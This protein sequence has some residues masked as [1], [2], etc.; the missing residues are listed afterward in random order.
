MSGS[1]L[2]ARICCFICHFWHSMKSFWTVV[3]TEETVWRRLSEKLLTC[4]RL[5]NYLWKEPADESITT[6][7][8]LQ[9]SKCLFFVPFRSQWCV[10]AWR[11]PSISSATRRSL[12]SRGWWRDTARSISWLLS[13]A[14][15]PAPSAPH[16]LWWTPPSH[17]WKDAGGASWRRATST[18]PWCHEW[19]RPAA[20]YTTSVRTEETA[21]CRSGTLR[22][23]PLQVI[24][25]SPTLN[26]M[27]RTRTALLRWSDTPSPITCWLYCSTEP[28]AG[29]QC[30]LSRW[31]SSSVETEPSLLRRRNWVVCRLACPLLEQLTALYMKIFSKFKKA[32][33]DWRLCQKSDQHLLLF[34][35]PSTLRQLKHVLNVTVVIRLLRSSLF[36]K[37]NLHQWTIICCA[38][39]GRT[40]GTLH[41][42]DFEM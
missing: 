28:S 24:W 12:W 42:A 18:S 10:T 29:P 33:R 1:A 14:A 34:M 38:V 22:W 7:M 3:W 6:L 9:L 8:V 27:R 39:I 37:I 20:F 30:Y 25:Y 17:G 19:W 5:K 41:R 35:T 2:N 23:R 26:R 4:Y 16:A 13:S 36:N 11:S 15:S 31:D 32:D 21:S 40:D